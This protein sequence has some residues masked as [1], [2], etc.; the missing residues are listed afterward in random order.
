MY[1]FLYIKLIKKGCY[2]PCKKLYLNCFDILLTKFIQND[3]LEANQSGL[4]IELH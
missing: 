3:M 1:D 4:S 2:V